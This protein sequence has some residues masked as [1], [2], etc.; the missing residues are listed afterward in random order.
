[1][2]K[3]DKKNDS[4][5]NDAMLIEALELV[6]REKG[7]DKEV[8]FE[9]IESSLVSACKK[10]FGT[11]QNI[12]VVINRENGMVTV[13]AK[14]EIVEDLNDDNLEI[15]LDEAKKI[16]IDYSL[17]DF[18]NVVVTPKDFGRISAQT[19]KQ[20]VVKKFREAESETLYN[21][22]IK[23]E[24]EIMTG[25]VQR[26]ERNNIII[27]LDKIEAMLQMSEKIPNEKYELNKRVKVYVLEVKQTSK[28]TVM[29]VSRTHPELVKRLFE[30]EVPEI[31]EGIVEIKSISR[32]AGSRTKISVYSKDPNIDPVGA[33]V[34]QNGCRVNVIVDELNGEKIDIIEYN[35]NLKM[36]I[37]SALSPSKVVSVT[38]K[39]DGQS[40]NIVVPDNQ[41]SLAIGKEGQNV[42]LAAKLTSTRI[43]IKSESQ[44]IEMQVEEPKKDI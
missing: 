5:K 28:G 37:S 44:A 38:I 13:L 20:V 42:R 25:I 15:S 26:H 6:S 39:E 36:Y 14:K 21:E 30:Q 31:R 2:K 24:K 40:A 34:G 32:E 29:N 11:S 18:I 43:D 1:L 22:Y 4:K 16:N 17:G 19:A 41:L 35:D 10:N 27:S 8:I 3:T 7:I 12:S 9:A 23:K 33:C